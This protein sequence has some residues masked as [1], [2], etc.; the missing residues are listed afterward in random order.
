MSSAS[1]HSDEE[2]LC[3]R[4][5]DYQPPLPEEQSRASRLIVKIEL[6]LMTAIMLALGARFYQTHREDKSPIKIAAMHSRTA[7]MTELP[8]DIGGASDSTGIDGADPTKGQVLYM[9]TCTACHGQNLGGMPHQGI[10]LRDSKFIAATNDRKLVAFIKMGRKPADAKNTTG[11]LMP[12]RGGNPALDDDA[13]ASIVAFLRQV[14]KE[15][16]PTLQTQAASP[17]T[18]PMATADPQSAGAGA[19][20]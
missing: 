19:R 13:L 2:L 3:S 10:S 16:N 12:P 1:N 20:D 17:T 8:P 11:L 9:Q 7:M 15:S 6:A 18:R 4:S 14:Q 5:S